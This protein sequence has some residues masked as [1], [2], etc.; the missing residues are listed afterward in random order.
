MSNLN[1]RISKWLEEENLE[2]ALD[3]VGNFFIN[4]SYWRGEHDYL[5]IVSVMI[6]WASEKGLEKQCGE[7]FVNAVRS[8]GERD[9][10]KALN[11]LLAYFVNC[12]VKKMSLPIQNLYLFGH[13]KE[14][15]NTLS[16]IQGQVIEENSKLLRA[17]QDTYIEFQ[18]IMGTAG[19][20]GSTRQ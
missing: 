13:F 9:F 8:I 5:L 18:K 10:Q 7:K 11:I 19:G 4:N 17:A 15:L 20:S 2:S 1:P 3:G 14:Q 16:N 6:D 12:K